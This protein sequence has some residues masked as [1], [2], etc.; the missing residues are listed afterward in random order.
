MNTDK[1]KLLQETEHLLTDAYHQLLRAGW[2]N[3]LLIDRIKTKRDEIHQA[4]K[5]ADRSH[6]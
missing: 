5:P 1:E 6:P 2:E 4:L 3:D